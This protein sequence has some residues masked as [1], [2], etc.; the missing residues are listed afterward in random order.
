M[1]TVIIPAE[2]PWAYDEMKADLRAG[3]NQWRE[4]TA[5]FAEQALNVLP[6]IYGVRGGFLVSEPFTHTDRGAIYAGFIAL[7]GRHFA[8]YSSAR[9]FAGKCD[10]L[11]TA[12]AAP[13]GE[14]K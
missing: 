6:P 13:A 7:D 8:R 1:N 2:K 4:V 12:L 11:R 9:D 10:E 14:A 5:E 3:L